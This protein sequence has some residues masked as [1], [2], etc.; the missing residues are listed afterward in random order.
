[1]TNPN[2]MEE[3]DSFVL[4]TLTA[5]LDRID[6]VADGFVIQMQEAADMTVSEFNVMNPTVGM[7]TTVVVEV[8][9]PTVYEADGYLLMILPS[10]VTINPSNLNCLFWFGFSSD[11][12]F[13]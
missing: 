9:L 10:T 4:T 1:M 13:D 6:T 8:N 12:D 11:S 3:T 2:T 7:I 5:A